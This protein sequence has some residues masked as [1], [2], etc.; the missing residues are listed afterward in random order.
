LHHHKVSIQ[1][2][3]K[4]LNLKNNYQEESYSN[5]W[6]E[7]VNNKFSSKHNPLISNL[8]SHCNNFNNTIPANK[9]I[10]PLEW[11]SA[12][13]LRSAFKVVAQ[14]SHLPNKL[15]IKSIE[16]VWYFYN[17]IIILFIWIYFLIDSN[18]NAGKSTRLP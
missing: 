4:I 15:M 1:T 9:L 7:L 17:T 14:L 13:Q 10:I 8:I 16:M 12:H 18:K 2:Q 3:V 6:I 5:Q 11:C